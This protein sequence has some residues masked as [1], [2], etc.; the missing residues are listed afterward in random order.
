V[1]THSTAAS[2]ARSLERAEMM[3]SKIAE[4]IISDDGISRSH[5]VMHSSRYGLSAADAVR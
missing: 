4:F 3:V 5:D 2:N 1:Q